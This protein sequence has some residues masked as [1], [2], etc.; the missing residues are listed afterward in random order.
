MQLI[1][2]RRDGTARLWLDAE[3]ELCDGIGRRLTVSDP[4]ARGDECELASYVAAWLENAAERDGPTSYRCI[5]PD[6]RALVY[7]MAPSAIVDRDDH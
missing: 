1:V 3:G 2:L 5:H 7:A 6:L 4:E